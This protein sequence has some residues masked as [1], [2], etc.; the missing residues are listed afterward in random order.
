MSSQDCIHTAIVYLKKKAKEMKKQSNQSLVH[1]QNKLVK[2][3]FGLDSMAQLYE[4][5]SVQIKEVTDKNVEFEYLN[6][7]Q[8]IFYGKNHIG[9]YLHRKNTHHMAILT[10]SDFLNESLKNFQ[11]KS[12]E[13]IKNYKNHEG[14]VFY[15]VKDLKK[16]SNI[17]KKIL[18]QGRSF[19]KF[20]IFDLKLNKVNRQTIRQLNYLDNVHDLLL[21]KKYFEKIYDVKKDPLKVATKKVWFCPNQVE[22]II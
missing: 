7:K 4:N 21:S 12:Q 13:E 19:E 14:K 5:T 10:S 16:D 1:I 2:E 11:I 18:E 22:Y 8:A 6:K 9:K 20:I 15:V 3:I 17:I